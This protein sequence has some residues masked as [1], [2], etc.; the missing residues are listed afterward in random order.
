M[1][2]NLDNE[3]MISIVVM[4]GLFLGIVLAYLERETIEVVRKVRQMI[5][6]NGVAKDGIRFAP[7]CLSLALAISL[8]DLCEI[9][10]TLE[11]FQRILLISGSLAVLNAVFILLFSLRRRRRKAVCNDVEEPHK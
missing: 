8:F 7:F 4:C 10:F 2:Y 6:F 5:K 3:Q 9:T 1:I 11:I